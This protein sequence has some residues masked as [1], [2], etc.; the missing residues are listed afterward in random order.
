V[1]EG[2]LFAEINADTDAGG[3]SLPDPREYRQ[4]PKYS[5]CP[6]CG[7][8]RLPRRRTSVRMIL[9][10]RF[11]TVYVNKAI[12]AWQGCVQY[13]SRASPDVDAV[14]ASVGG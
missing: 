10:M 4:I 12:H 13:K 11:V 3:R 7:F 2:Q 5:Y 6:Q 9:G 1:V 14:R 8:G